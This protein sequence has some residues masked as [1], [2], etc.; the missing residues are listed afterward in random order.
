MKI[1]LLF[2]TFFVL[3]SAPIYSQAMTVDNSFVTTADV[4]SIVENVLIGGANNCA[5][6]E[7]LSK[8]T[9]VDSV[10]NGTNGIGTFNATGTNFPFQ[11]GI[12]LMSGDITTIPGPNFPNSPT[13]GGW[14]DSDADLEANTNAI[15]TEAASWIQ[16]DFTPF[17]DEL[18]FNF[19][20]ASEEYDRN[21]E[22]TFS[23][24][25]AF[26]LTDLTTGTVTNLAVLP[27][28]T[29]P[30]EVTNIH[31]E[32]PGF[33]AAQNEQFFGGYNFIDFAPGDPV[34]ANSAT[35]FNGQTVSLTATSPVII[36]NTYRIKLVV[37]DSGGDS[38]NDVGVFLEAGS[39]NLGVNLGMDMSI[40]GNNAACDG[41]T[42]ILDATG[43]ATATTTY[44]WQFF[45][46]SSGVFEPFVPAETSGTLDVIVGGEYKVLVDNG[47][48]CI[49]EDSILVEFVNPVANDVPDLFECDD[50]SNDG[51][52]VF[53]LDAQISDII[54]TQDATDLTVTFHTSQS[55]ADM[56]MFP[57]S[58]TDAYTNSIINSEEIFVRVSSISGPTCFDTTM[59]SIN[60]VSRPTAQIP[61]NPYEV[62]DDFTGGSDTDGIATFDLS[63][64]NAEILNGQDP[65]QFVVS[66]FASQADAV[67]GSPSLPF[68]F[69][70][71]T[72]GGQTIVARVENTAFA[73]CFSTTDVVLVVNELPVLLN[74]VVTL[75]QCDTDTDG[76]V[77]YNL[78]QAQ[79]ELSADSVNETFT[80]FDAGGN[81]IADPTNFTNA[82]PDENISVIVTTA[83]G[84]SRNADLILDTTASQI[85]AGTFEDFSQ[86]DT[87]GDGI[88]V[89]D[90][91]G[92][93][94][95]FLA[96]FPP[97]PPL[98]VSY[99][100][101]EQEAQTE[102][103]P[104]TNTSA[105]ANDLAYTDASG[106]Q[107]I[108]VRID[109]DDDNDCV[110]LGLHVRLT[111][112][113]N[114]IITPGV[115]DLEECSP[116]A[117]SAS[118]D[119][120]QNDAAATGGNPDYAVT[121]YSGIANYTAA[122]PVAIATP[123]AFTNAVNPQ[124]IYYS[125]EDTSGSGCTTFDTAM[126]FQVIV[127]QDPVLVAPSDLEACDTDGTDDGSTLVDLSSK[128]TEITGGFDANLTVS[129]HLDQNGA[130]TADGSIPDKT[131]FTNTVNPQVVYARVGNNT[132]GCSSTVPLRIEIF[133]VPTP[134]A[135]T[136]F[137][138]CDPDNDGIFDAFVLS[139]KDA[140]ITGG[141]PGL[142]VTYYLTMS[143]AQNAPA[144]LELDAM[145]YINNDPF[146][147]TIFARVS[148]AQGCFGVVPLELVVLDTPMPNEMPAPYALCDDDTDGLQTFDLT[149]QEVQILGGLDPAVYQV[150]WYQDQASA[151][152]GT[153]V[154][155]DPTAYVSASTNDPSDTIEAVVAVVTDI[156]QSP[157]TSCSEDVSLDLIVNPLPVP[158]QPAEYE[159][160]DDLA[161]GSD[162]D[163]FSVFDLRSR[164]DEI[165]GGNNDLT[166]SY[167]ATQAEAIAG[168]PELVD[169]YQN[170]VMAS[171]TIWARVENMVTGCPAT[172]TLTLVV[173]PLPS[174]TTIPAVEACDDDG[175][176]DAVFDLTGQVTTDIIN[177]EAFVS[178]T[179]HQT[180]AAAEI[181]TPQI[182]DP[183]NYET[184]SRT[185]WVR[186]TDS[187]PATATACYRIVELELT[188]NPAPVLPTDI[189]D[190]TG[191]DSDGNGQEL[192]DLTQNDAV[193]Y[194][195]QP[196]T[197][198]TLTY[199]ETLASA[200]AET[201]TAMDMPVGDPV[202]YLAVAPTTTLWVRLEDNTTGC[203]S[204]GSFDLNVTPIPMIT[205]PG[206]LEACDSAGAGVG[207]D[208]DGVTTFDLTGLDAGITGGDTTLSVT[209]YESQADLDAGTANAI[210]APGAYINDGTDPQT[211][212]ILVTSSGAGMCAAQTTVDLQVNPLPQLAAPLADA[213]ACDEDND[214][215][216]GFDLQ[217]YAATLG[218]GLMDVELLFYET[219]DN[220]TAGTATGQID[221][222]VPYNNITGMT[223]LFVLARDTD[224]ATATACAKIYEF[225]LVVFPI[226]VLP[227]SLDTLTE[228]DD[229]GDGDELFDLTQNEAAIYGAQDPAQF[230]ITYH[231]SGADAGAGSAPIL[232][233]ASYTGT[234]AT[235]PETIW[236]RLTT[237]D[238]SGNTCYAVGSFDIVV[239]DPPV[240]NPT[241]AALDIAIC[242]D[243]AAAPPQTVFDLTVNNDTITGMDPLLTVTYYAGLADLASGTPIADP[244]AYGNTGN[245]QTIQAVVSSVAGCTDVTSFDIRV[246]PLPTPNTDPAPPEECDDDTDGDATNGLTDFDLEAVALEIAGGEMVTVTIFDDAIFAEA[247]PIDPMTIVASAATGWDFTNTVAGNQT[248]YARVD[249]DLPGNP[250]FVVVPFEVIVSPLPIV[251]STFDNTYTFCEEF[252]G[253]DTM[254]SLELTTL[255]DMMG[256]LAAPQATADFDITYH[257][258][259]VQAQNN[260]A[261][262]TSPYTVADGE[263]LFIRIEN[264]ATGCVSFSS[265][266]VTVETR[267]GVFPADAIVQ[268]ADDLGVNQVPDQDV[269][270]FDLTQQN[271]V[272][273]GG[274][275][276]TSVVYYTSLADAQAME[277]AI[278]APTA[279]V[280]MGNPQTIYARAVN[281]ASGCESTQ[282]VEFDLIVRPLPYTD[283]GDQGGD[284]CVDQDTGVALDPFILDGT[285]ETPQPGATYSYAW[286]LDGALISL[287]PQ[288]TVSGAGTYQVTVTATYPD[289]T[290][291]DYVAEAVYVA[292]SAPVFEAVV[293]EGSFNSSGLY[294]VAVI[295]VTGFGDGPYEFALDDGP[296]LAFEQGFTFT[297]VAPGTHTIFGRLASGECSVS[298]VEIGIIDYPRFFTPNSDGFHDT[299]NIIGLGTAP[300][301]NAKIFIFDRYGKLLK[302]ISPTSAGWDGTFNGQPMP[303]S[304]YWFRVEFTE[305]DETGTQRTVNGHFTLKR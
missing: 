154:I 143:D 59:F 150:V 74:T 122:P 95:N 276:G 281:T 232:N 176:G 92:A 111:V 14:T 62:C 50:P 69:T 151:D 283:L 25:F 198:Y 51:F 291:C 54:G 158:V 98:T 101:T 33:C 61:A 229:D 265:V 16:F 128:D 305:N 244:T 252:D 192:F 202:N 302:Q 78:T 194:G 269:A 72:A 70:N 180:L 87:D 40:A 100:E 93:T 284:I 159:L 162:T 139:D 216:G 170:T 226:P 2:T 153:P 96:L 271:A 193:I 228:C 38:I 247:D 272:I 135:P 39:F 18:N 278:G 195:A 189:P 239:E 250:C 268:C 163:E 10:E 104:I 224:P 77:V 264:I 64:Q 241:G 293:V 3:L 58:G 246:L 31:P 267:P 80:Y 238:G 83:N 130:D 175:D 136:P 208:D 121:Y 215:F 125:L 124:T 55:N 206:V 298:E 103:N 185:I 243:D 11:E 116:I 292:Q 17:V 164:D 115:P 140:E 123:T 172:I 71:T 110:G 257:Q 28:T 19:I 196:T 129:Y 214:G 85:P 231:N 67:A 113:P 197:D 63:T 35:N 66:Y 188:V 24:A 301:L 119:L 210:A 186:A 230:T 13:G 259:A 126:N 107:G 255:A 200:G 134:V 109:S 263:E 261:A 160:C 91:S 300:N 43:N 177:G 32:V 260:A 131:M 161:S 289:G 65:V 225:A 157:T 147:Q 285:V 205:P 152:A 36:G 97:T 155:P 45:N 245:P 127:N 68:A 27:G 117:N 90:F 86:C 29:I 166:V 254:G 275:T 60:V 204:I 118:F 174:P 30:I 191:C 5:N 222:T 112:D 82:V 44:E 76:I 240:A 296:F 168:T 221:I 295:N 132:T 179:F 7:N 299:W 53:D 219:L 217:G 169:M 145:M 223:S 253:D 287:D 249:S 235:S 141:D 114:P 4:Q 251:S 102:V 15:N 266:V 34:A 12:V 42:I 171:E 48:G 286:T 138:Q 142:T 8:F 133:A 22:C 290:Q 1:A 26:L 81:A 248:L 75:E 41:E 178:L 182:A 181:G 46:T 209:Y 108:W 137:E 120:T 227:A 144:G 207:T 23:D 89:F 303:S 47:T 236:V 148:S 99:Y 258:Q 282:V 218:A 211:L 273:T 304:D 105:Y 190:L 49:G 73:D 88:A 288:V 9:G 212:F 37:A 146:N 21:F 242:D 79:P 262:L 274:N 201:G 52:E 156:A 173:N 203:R 220:A 94:A 297:S 149:S 187:D 233:A 84:C 199:H 165:T 183:A 279:F 56:A 184:V 57:L 280:N 106:V 270:T 167:H 277:N 294:T 213:V 256:L 234:T 237:S 6:I 20:M